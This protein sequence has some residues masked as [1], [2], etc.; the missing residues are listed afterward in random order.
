MSVLT[1][2]TYAGIIL[3]ILGICATA[4]FAIR[5][6]ERKQPRMQFLTERKIE[7]PPD[8]PQDI[9][10]YFKDAKV[11]R[12]C[13]TVVWFWNDGKTPIRAEDIPASQT[14]GIRLEDP[15]GPLEILSVAVQAVTRPA[16]GFNASAR[17]SSEAD[18]KFEF[19]DQGDGARFEIL[20]TGSTQTKGIPVGV[21]LGAP[22]GVQIVDPSVLPSIVPFRPARRRVSMVTRL[23]VFTVTMVVLGGAAAFLFQGR[24]DVTTTPDRVREALH[25]QLKGD[26]LEAAVIAV[27]NT[28]KFKFANQFV[29]Y[30]MSGILA[31]QIVFS[32]VLFLKRPYAFPEALVPD[33]KEHR[34]VH[35]VVP[36]V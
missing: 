32:V 4:Y 20:H 34:Q 15:D 7:A 33:A 21:I 12:V 17:T 11:G 29:A 14:L 9:R 6:S 16:I 1:I 24:G 22:R 23:L 30:G 18:L 19:L 10:I 35:G 2:L 31:I 8:A 13:A 28:A 36:K 3:A 27:T 5:Y 26:G 25:S